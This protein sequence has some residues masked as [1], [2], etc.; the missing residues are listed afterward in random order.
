MISSV[1]NILKGFMWSA[2]KKSS[3]Q[4]NREIIA[5]KVIFFMRSGSMIVF[6]LL[7]VTSK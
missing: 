2:S 7:A 6:L 5:E 4:R 1:A 3:A